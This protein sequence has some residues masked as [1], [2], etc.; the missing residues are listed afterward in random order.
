MLRRSMSPEP[1]CS[2]PRERR[3]ARVVAEKLGRT[4][5]VVGASALLVKLFILLRQV[6]KEH[7]DPQVRAQ[8]RLVVA[9]ALSARE[10]ILRSSGLEDWQPEVARFAQRHLGV[11]KLDAAWL[12][13]ASMALLGEWTETVSV[14]APDGV[15]ALDRLR[16]EALTVHRQLM[17]LWERKSGPGRV[18]MLDF[19]LPSGGD[20]HEVVAVSYRIEDEA[21]LW[22]PERKDA[23]AVFQR[24]KADE[25]LVARAYALAGGSWA[26]AAD[27]AYLPK[28]IGTRVMRKLRRLGEQRRATVS[29]PDCST[30]AVAE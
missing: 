12:E 23:R 14:P 8:A 28:E 30:A 1:S 21:L 16:Q 27:Y 20:L 22:E 2:E 29:L 9:E 19:L 11:S 15:D 24:L 7:P 3:R 25:Q 4:I 5:L 17:P 10:A 18:W 6:A 13:A 26:E